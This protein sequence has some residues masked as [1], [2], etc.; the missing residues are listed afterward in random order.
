M[1]PWPMQQPRTSSWRPQAPIEAFWARS[2]GLEER[3]LRKETAL[4]ALADALSLAVCGEL[5]TP[6]DFRG[7]G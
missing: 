1:L 6:V 7:A 5:T 4:V 3:A 2:L